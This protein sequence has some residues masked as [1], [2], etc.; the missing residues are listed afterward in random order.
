LS[1]NRSHIALGS[2]LLNFVELQVQIANQYTLVNEHRKKRDQY[3]EKTRELMRE[4]IQLR[5]ERV[6]FIEQAK[7]EQKKRDEMNSK[8]REYK[9]QRKELNEEIKKARERLNE[10]KQG[11]NELEDN[12]PSKSPT[13]RLMRELK[14]SEWIIQTT[15]MSLDKERELVKKIAKLEAQLEEKTTAQNKINEFQSKIIEE[16]ASLGAIKAKLEHSHQKVIDYAKKAQEHHDQ[17]EKL[18]LKAKEF[19]KRAD[20]LYKQ[21]LEVKKL[22][23]DEHKKAV[24]IYEKIDMLKKEINDLK[25][26]EEEEKQRRIDVKLEEKEKVAVQKLKEKRKKLTMEEFRILVEKG[27]I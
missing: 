10:L 27:L 8:V 6:K 2:G 11:R 14:D 19:E 26:T 3:N 16:A 23:D 7:N 1:D 5:E 4:S 24:K 18:F 17:M 22:A 12:S 25:K 20:E 21:F 15:V 13:K 9:E